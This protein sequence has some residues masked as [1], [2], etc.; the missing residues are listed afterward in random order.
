MLQ[1]SEWKNLSSFRLGALDNGVC[2]GLDR[3]CWRRSSHCTQPLFGCCYEELAQMEEFGLWESKT[4]FPGGD[5]GKG[6]G[7]SLSTVAGNAPAGRATQA[8]GSCS[9]PASLQHLVSVFCCFFFFFLSI[10]CRLLFW[11]D[12]SSTDRCNID[13]VCSFTSASHEPFQCHCLWAGLLEAAAKKQSWIK[14]TPLEICIRSPCPALQIRWL[15]FS[16]GE[17][18]WGSPVLRSSALHFST[19]IFPS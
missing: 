12:S 6:R 9:I 4:F 10:R 2:W 3:L 19:H 5:A 7:T 16:A 1:D 14:A 18:I 13:K 8:W 11:Y 15:V 17:S